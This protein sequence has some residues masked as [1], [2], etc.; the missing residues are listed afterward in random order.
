MSESTIPDQ[1]IYALSMVRE[2][3]K[4]NMMD[5]GGVVFLVEMEC[6]FLAADWIRHAD[7]DAY[8]TALNEMGRRRMA[9]RES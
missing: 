6:D 5:R 7:A 2:T 4:V 8:M 3:G 9:D 1:V